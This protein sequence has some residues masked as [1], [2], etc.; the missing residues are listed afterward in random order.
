MNRHWILGLLWMG[1]L[2]TGCYSDLT[3]EEAPEEENQQ[4]ILYYGRYTNMAWVPTDYGFF[5]TQ[6][7][8]VYSFDLEGNSNNWERPTDEGYAP[9][10]LEQNLAHQSEYLFSLESEWLARHPEAIQLISQQVLSE[11][12]NRGADQGTISL[13]VLDQ[14]PGSGIYREHL[15]VVEGDGEVHREGDTAQE[16]GE[17]LRTV[18]HEVLEVN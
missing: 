12:T 2:L 7:G 8:E 10:S 14:N 4:E 5:I 17:W 16:V 18:Y 15:V 6:Y 13:Y 11:A 9:G 1:A 3:L